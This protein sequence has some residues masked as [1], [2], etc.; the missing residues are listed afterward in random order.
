MIADDAADP[1]V[2]AVDLLSQAEHGPDSPAVLIT[3]S[4]TVARQA[5]AHIEKL[6]V[7][8]PTRDF[9]GPAWRDHGQILVVDSLGRGV[10]GRRRIRVRARAG[11]HPAAA[12]GARRDEELR[13]AVPG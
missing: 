8:M 13:G 5:L 7:D 2:V 11:A 10:H 4:A 9:A 3:T 12:A 6:L 1:F